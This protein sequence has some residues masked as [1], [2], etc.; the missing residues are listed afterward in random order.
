MKAFCVGA[1]RRRYDKLNKATGAYDPVDE[2]ILYV[3]HSSPIQGLHGDVTK[4]LALP[5][6][7]FDIVEANY[8]EKVVGRD[9]IIDLVP[10]GDSFLI[11]DVRQA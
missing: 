3:T 11:E 2:T 6:G 4:V 8:D 1:R 7:S 9:L 10:Y 5:Y